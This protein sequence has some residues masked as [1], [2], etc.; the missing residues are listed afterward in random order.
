VRLV[1]S[2]LVQLS[3]CGAGEWYGVDAVEEVL[4]DVLEND[5]AKFQRES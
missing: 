3:C 1:E 4:E 5:Y 2:W